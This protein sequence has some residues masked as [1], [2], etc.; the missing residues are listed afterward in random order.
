MRPAASTPST[1]EVPK[2]RPKFVGAA[3][4]HGARPKCPNQA[5]P[6]RG[7]PDLSRD[8]SLFKDRGFRKRGSVTVVDFGRVISL[9]WPG[10]APAQLLAWATQLSWL[11]SAARFGGS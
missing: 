6:G 9:A 2:I 4:R 3:A 10:L 1:L 11:A 5:R 7:V 8:P